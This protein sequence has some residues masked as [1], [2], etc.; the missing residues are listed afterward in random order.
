MSPA[1]SKLSSSVKPKCATKAGALRP[2][3]RV[4]IVAPAS[5]PEG[6]HT[7]AAI[8]KLVTGMGFVPVFGK[9]VLSIHGYMA[10][11]DDERLEDLNGFIR[12]KNI[13]GIF[14]TTGGYGSL[15]ILEGVD[16]EGLMRDPKVVVGSDENTCLLLAINKMASLPVFHGFNL[17]MIKSDRARDEFLYAVTQNKVLPPVEARKSYPANFVYSPIRGKASGT[18]L[19]G[20]LNALFSLMGTDYQP[21][22]KDTVLLIEERNE[23]NDIIER[24]ITSLFLSGELNLVNGI[25]FGNFETCGTR[26][27]SNMLSLEDILHPT[28]AKLQKPACFGM[29]FGQS[30]HCRVTPIGIEAEFD[31]ESGKLTFKEA[32]LL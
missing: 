6:P 17:D 14:C 4:G 1:K 31:S 7:V 19:G 2:G 30:E 11:K 24:W 32:A 28:L 25:A 18:T 10:G 26:S 22:F 23:R 9:H 5:R 27:A 16:Y 21:N 15:R 13:R 29:S 12:D 8:E 3:D 20:N